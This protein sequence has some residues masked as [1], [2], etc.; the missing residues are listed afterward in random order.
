MFRSSLALAVCAAALFSVPSAMAQTKVGVVSLQKAILDTAEIVR[1]RYH[2]KGYLHLKIMPGI[3]YEQLYRLMQLADRVSVNLEG[4]T[5]ERLNALAQQV[6]QFEAKM[7]AMRDQVN[8]F[9]RRQKVVRLDLRR[10]SR[11]DRRCSSRRK[12]PRRGTSRTFRCATRRAGHKKS[13]P[14]FC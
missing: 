14:E 5:Q 9:E 3:E 8:S 6:Q 2:Y 4:P 7:Q 11:A 13:V 12:L 10:L 1:R